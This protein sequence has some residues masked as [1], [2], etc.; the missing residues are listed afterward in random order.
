MFIA[1][2]E[3]LLITNGTGK[4]LRGLGDLLSVILLTDSHD[5]EQRAGSENCVSNKCQ[6]ELLGP[7]CRDLWERTKVTAKCLRSSQTTWWLRL[8]K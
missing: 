3:Q 7:F 2:L 6:S 8:N 4:I 1:I 5:P